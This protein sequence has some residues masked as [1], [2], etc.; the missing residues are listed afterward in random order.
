[1]IVP[2]RRA[3]CKH[4]RGVEIVAVC[5]R[6]TVIHD[7]PRDCAR[8]VTP[9]DPAETCNLIEAD[10]SGNICTKSARLVPVFGNYRTYLA[11]GRR[12]CL[13][14]RQSHPN[15]GMHMTMSVCHARMTSCNRK[16]RR[17]G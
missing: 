6:K 9:C 8:V 7:R 16:P 10:R 5:D 15:V 2:I 1:M 12:A 17:L 11:I 4:A 14:L 3:C 13:F